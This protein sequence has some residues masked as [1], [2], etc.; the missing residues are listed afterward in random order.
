M[1]ERSDFSPRSPRPIIRASDMTFN[2]V[3]LFALFAIGTTFRDRN[4][5]RFVIALGLL[6]LM[7]VL[8][9]FV[10]VKAIYALQLGAWSLANHGVISRNV[11]GFLDHFYR[12]VGMYALAFGLWWWLGDRVDADASASPGGKRR[13]TKR[14][15]KS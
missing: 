7:H 5:G 4:V 2:I 9:L 3:L 14:V 10:R 8:F 15:R 13:A 12:V 11:W 1:V 6:L